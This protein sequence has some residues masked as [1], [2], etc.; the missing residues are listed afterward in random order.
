MNI[1]DKL[2]FVYKVNRFRNGMTAKGEEATVTLSALCDKVNSI[3]KGQAQVSGEKAQEVHSTTLNKLFK[4]YSASGGVVET[5]VKAF[6]YA[7]PALEKWL[8]DKLG[9]P[10]IAKATTA[11]A[12]YDVLVAGNGIDLLEIVDI[13]EKGTSAKL[14]EF[15]LGSKEREMLEVLAECLTR[16]QSEA[17]GSSQVWQMPTEP[18]CGANFFTWLLQHN[19]LIRRNYDKIVFL[20]PGSMSSTEQA[21]TP[22]RVVRPKFDEALLAARRELGQTGTSTAEFAQFLTENRILLVAWDCYHL[23]LAGVKNQRPNLVELAKGLNSGQKGNAVLLCVGNT[24]EF[25][26]KGAL[27]KGTTNR[28]LPKIGGETHTSR[29]FSKCR[30]KKQ[31]RVEY[32]HDQWKRFNVIRGNATLEEAGMRPKRALSYYSDYNKRPV[33]PI[34]IRH[35][36]LFATNLAEFSFFDPTQGYDRLVGELD[37]EP[38]DVRLHRQEMRDYLTFIDSRR[39][40]RMQPFGRTPENLKK[41]P[42]S[43]F[44][45]FASTAKYW[46]GYHAYQNV[47]SVGVYVDLFSRCEDKDLEYPVPTPALVK[48]TILVEHDQVMRVRD[49]ELPNENKGHRYSIPLSLKAYIQDRWRLERPHDRAVAHHRV[50]SR[51]AHSRNDSIMLKL[52]FPYSPFRGD[53]RLFFV[54]ETLRHLMRSLQPLASV[55]GTRDWQSKNVMRGKFPATPTSD[56]AG[57]LERNRHVVNY[58]FARLYQESINNHRRQLSRAFGGVQLDVELLQILGQEGILGEPHEYL[59]PSQKQTY[60]KQCGLAMLDIGDLDKAEECFEKLKNFSP[61]DGA[62]YTYEYGQLDRAVILKERGKDK[63]AEHILDELENSLQD[64]FEQTGRYLAGK[65]KKGSKSDKTRRA[66]NLVKRIK[67]QQAYIK[68]DRKDFKGARDA[69]LAVLPDLGSRKKLFQKFDPVSVDLELRYI[70]AID[71]LSAQIVKESP[72]ESTRLRDWARTL[73]NSQA[74]NAMTQ[75][76]PHDGMRYLI[77]LGRI[78]RRSGSLDEAETILFHVQRILQQYGGSERVFF[79]AAI[80]SGRILEEISRKEIKCLEALVLED[81]N[82]ANQKDLLSARAKFMRAYV[83]Y[84]RPAYQRAEARGY[85][86]DK[87]IAKL[88]C[89]RML[90]DAKNMFKA[91]PDESTWM[92]VLDKAREEQ[93][94]STSQ[95]KSYD[96]ASKNVREAFFGYTLEH[97]SDGF[98]LL[99]DIDEIVLEIA[100]ISG[101]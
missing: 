2:K 34:D 93:T 71:R 8:E 90:K 85:I 23:N 100:H 6:E 52:E 3:R 58:C 78:Q 11:E 75:D 33:W 81:P 49:L 48:N 42:P 51:L 43:R 94:R 18:L 21:A 67:S 101:E 60:L 59:H 28:V 16:G 77:L 69:V 27:G 96:D 82:D 45:E 14:D 87:R 7:G 46:L 68:Y 47:P 37:S 54:A 17:R 72:E 66:Y 80:E 57:I 63:E 35:R 64:L 55:D 99:G 5:Y 24:V 4:D 61:A 70:S 76:Y 31:K 22:L 44:L 98:T 74:I 19:A 86:R 50:A 26:P 65:N 29:W 56:A 10:G 89:L 25:N 41:F 30:I 40:K 12:L 15:A 91:M 20:R 95:R 1:F 97:V 9:I 38:D 39:N 13:S 32:F 92:A 36:A 84:Y 88:R 62:K 73:T 79:S 83:A 53:S